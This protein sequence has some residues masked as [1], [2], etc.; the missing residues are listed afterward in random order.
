VRARVFF[1]VN[2]IV[3]AVS[4]SAAHG[5]ELRPGYKP[6]Q[7]VSGR[8]FPASET[9]MLALRDH[10]NKRAVAKMRAHAWDLFV[11]LTRGDPAWQTW[12]TKCDLKL[13]VQECPTVSQSGIAGP[14]HLFPDF[15]IPVQSFEFLAQL[16]TAN[17]QARGESEAFLLAA[18]QF[19]TD[20]RSHP[21]YASVLFN[22]EASDHILMNCLYPQ[23]SGSQQSSKLEC[24]ASP[25]RAN[26]ILP[27]ER[28]SIVL[29]TV[30]E[31]AHVNPGKGASIAGPLST[32]NSELWNHIHST[33]TNPMPFSKGIVKI[34]T[35]PQ[36][37]C[38]DRDYDDEE[39]VPLLCFYY[40]KLTA[41]DVRL[42]PYSLAAIDDHHLIAG[43]YLILVGLHVTTK[44]IPEWVWATF[45]WDN[46]SFSDR[47]AK[48]RPRALGMQWRH[49][50]M[51]TT[52]S[53]MTP[54][55]RD[56]GPKIC[57][58][59]YLE[60]GISNGIISNCVQCHNLAG[61]GNSQESAR[62][63][64]LGILGRDRTNLASGHAPNP[65]YF[66]NFYKTDFLWSL[67]PTKDTT[68]RDLIVA[69]QTLAESRVK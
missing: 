9:R 3:L 34:D 50:L 13:A 55:E 15:E 68:L 48:G 7:P 51:D 47:H 43:D 38:E 46:H 56:K 57:F 18:N 54:Y 61:Y 16:F 69:M 14:Q 33:D 63:Y 62:P 17:R 35:T 22:K 65:N 53:G 25:Q 60:T 2:I 6:I 21:Q 20:F 66:N 58:N 29:K 67:V 40:Y 32:W 37:K 12:Y 28:G 31:V 36:K 52:L 24:R 1:E 4:M 44:E 59:P 5:Q 19:L 8:V 23:A 39:K 49:F 27:F 41:E 64:E 10:P 11:G 42:F 45:W 26:E 30:W